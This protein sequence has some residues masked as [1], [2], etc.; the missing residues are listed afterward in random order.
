MGRQND[1]PSKRSQVE[2]KLVKV[3]G[4]AWHH[5]ARLQ[6]RVLLSYFRHQ[7]MKNGLGALVCCGC[8]GQCGQVRPSPS[9]PLQLPAPAWRREYHPHGRDGQAFLGG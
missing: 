1:G 6:L 5:V 4:E 7:Q 3:T 8:V 2:F 9:S